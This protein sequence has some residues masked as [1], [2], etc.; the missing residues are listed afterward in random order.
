MTPGRQV[1]AS[2]NPDIV[3]ASILDAAQAEFMAEGYAG[4][5]TNRI[6]E[7][8]GR[9]KPT[10]FRHFPTKRALFEGVVARIAERWSEQV[11]W[12]GIPTDVPDQWLRSFATRALQ[13]V[14]SDDT[15][16]VSR[17]GVAAGHEFPEIVNTF[18][19]L[20]VEPIQR[21]IADRLRAWAK[22]GLL[23]C[24]DPKQDAEAFLDITISG[25]VSRRLYG[26]PDL[27]ESEVRR[28]MERRVT[29]FLKGMEARPVSRK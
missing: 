10:V 27:S 13:W 23:R 5:S 20:A 9:S 6:V 25:L 1:S 14:M 17:M 4:A 28:H 12:R 11:D 2:R 8:F 24:T 3:R 15:I 18:R 7:R 22:A 26:V 21:V 19:S 16:F 29:I